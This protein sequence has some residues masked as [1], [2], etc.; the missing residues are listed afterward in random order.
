[1]QAKVITPEALAKP[2][3]R[4]NAVD[5]YEK[6]GR[7]RPCAQAIA[8]EHRPKPPT[9]CEICGCCLKTAYRG[10]KVCANHESHAKLL[11]YRGIADRLRATSGAYHAEATSETKAL[12]KLPNSANPR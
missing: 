1:M 11:H 9:E 8:L 10:R 7:C 3:K 6:S 12:I 2:C 5:R 4:C